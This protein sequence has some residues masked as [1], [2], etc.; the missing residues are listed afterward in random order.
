VTGLTWSGG[1]LYAS[2]SGKHGVE[3]FCQG[4]DRPA[5]VVSIAP[6]EAATRTELVLPAGQL[7]DDLV[8]DD[9]SV[10]MAIEGTMSGMGVDSPTTDDHTGTILRAPRG[11]S[12]SSVVAKGIQFVTFLTMD[13]ARVF[14]SSD[15]KVVPIAK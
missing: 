1:R 5:S 8:V 13:D 10:W 6:G 2:I 4:C 12:T 9:A 15:G 3:Y 14:Y 11:S 7:I